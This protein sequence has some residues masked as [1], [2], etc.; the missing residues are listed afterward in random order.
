[1]VDPAAARFVCMNVPEPGGKYAQRLLALLRRRWPSIAAFVVLLSLFDAMRAWSVYDAPDGFVEGIVTSVR[2]GWM[3][4]LAAALAPYLVE[5]ANFRPIPRAV[6]SV[7]VT[8]FLVAVVALVVGLLV[9]GPITPGVRDGRLLS[10]EAFLV[11][12]CWLYSVAG[13]LFAAYCQT[14]DEG[15]ATLRAARAAE[16][17]RADSQRNILASRLQVLQ[18]RMEPELLFGALRDVRGAYLRDPTAAESLLDDLIGYL[19]AALPQM[20]GGAS[21][22]QREAALAE[23]YL[24]VVP[25]GRSRSLTV[26]LCIAHEAGAHAFP[27]MVLLPLAHAASAAVPLAIQIEAPATAQGVAINANSVAMRVSTSRI[28]DGWGEVE[29][30]AIRSTL[31][32]HFGAAASVRIERTRKSVSAIVTW[33]D[34]KSSSEPKESATLAAA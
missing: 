4:T 13:L 5:A 2:I 17:E 9:E 30:L 21:T 6:S 34:A 15:I 20:R 3:L 33:P 14:R 12:A 32:N 29:L 22:L 11:R 19:R 27:P 10:N 18:A 28:P 16:L 1:M 26:D 7:T 25:S 31:A 8:F 23:A 24:K